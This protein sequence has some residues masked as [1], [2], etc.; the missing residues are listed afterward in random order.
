MEY[1]SK[2]RRAKDIAHWQG[3]ERAIL[4]CLETLKANNDFKPFYVVGFQARYI[5]C[6]T[7]A[8]G[9]ISFVITIM[10][11]YYATLPPA[12]EATTNA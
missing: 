7:M 4:S 3:C 8:S 1:K 12:D 9:A 2:S 10:S 5:I 6:Q 11:M